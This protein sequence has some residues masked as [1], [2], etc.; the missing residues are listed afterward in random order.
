[1]TRTARLVLVRHAKTEKSNSGGDHERGLLP[2]GRGDAEAAGTWLAGGAV[3]V[4]DLVLCSSAVRARQTW[5]VMAAHPDLADVEVWVDGRIYH[6]SPEQL[7]DVVRE[8]PE[9]TRVLAM[10]GHAPGVPDLAEGLADREASAPAALDAIHQ[11]FPTMACA[12]L[13]PAA[14]WSDLEPGS[15]ALLQVATPRAGGGGPDELDPL[16]RAD[17]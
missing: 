12:I 4:P 7:L 13:E 16:S 8:A 17:R 1:M 3:L 9:S 10:V 6:A 14:D 2:R 5:E 11:G 15:A